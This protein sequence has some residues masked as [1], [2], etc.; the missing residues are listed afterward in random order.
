ML[1][2]IKVPKWLTDLNS[3][4]QSKPLHLPFL[5]RAAKKSFGSAHYSPRCPRKRDELQKLQ[6]NVHL[7]I[8]MSFLFSFLLCSMVGVPAPFGDIDLR[9]TGKKVKTRH[10]QKHSQLSTNPPSIKAVYSNHRNH[11]RQR[12]LY[13]E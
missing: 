1:W 13:D 11:Y 8:L 12:R 2:T 5:M 7:L 3:E 9:T 6:T 4:K 10:P